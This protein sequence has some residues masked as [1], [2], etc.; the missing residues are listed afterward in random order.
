M[1]SIRESVFETNSSSCHSITFSSKGS[2]AKPQE[3]CWLH[4]DF[5]GDDWG[6][7]HREYYDPQ[8][9][10]EYW[11]NAFVANQADK[12]SLENKKARGVDSY[13]ITSYTGDDPSKWNVTRGP[14]LEEVYN[15]I[16]EETKEKLK[17]VL[18]KFTEYQVEFFFTPS[19]GNEDN[20]VQSNEDFLRVFEEL[21]RITDEDKKNL[22]NN[23]FNYYV[24]LGYGIDHQ[25]APREDN[26]CKTLAELEPED[27]V[28]WVLGD[29]SFETDNDND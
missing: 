19:E 22:C 11:L 9:K 23:E 24:D 28:D 26:D 20:Y 6:W 3:N 5:R 29:G 4:L 15:K 16:L 14:C 7:E 13:W 21:N 1:L 12:M 25:S 17:A 27:V 10:F 18:D 8:A 2:A